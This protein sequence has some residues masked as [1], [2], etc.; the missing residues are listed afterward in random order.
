[1]LKM[2]FQAPSILRLK[3]GEAYSGRLIR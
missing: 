1:L 2:T 3:E